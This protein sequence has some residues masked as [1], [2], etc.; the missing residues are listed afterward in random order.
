MTPNLL[1]AM[2]LRA[3]RG[4]ILEIY[5]NEFSSR[6]LLY[7]HKVKIPIRTHVEFQKLISLVECLHYPQQEGV[8]TI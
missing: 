6:F 7:R 2:L 4:P 8:K 5:I 1:C 3:V